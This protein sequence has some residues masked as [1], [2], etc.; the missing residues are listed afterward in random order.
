MTRLV[1]IHLTNDFIFKLAAPEMYARQ[2]HAK[3]VLHDFTENI[4]EE[5]RRSLLDKKMNDNFEGQINVHQSI[6]PDTI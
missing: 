4:I 2:E 1:K 6:L 3:R 5:R